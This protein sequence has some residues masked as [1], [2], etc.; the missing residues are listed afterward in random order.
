M[1]RPFPLLPE[2]LLLD[3]IVQGKSMASAVRVLDTLVR[4]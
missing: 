2:S 1:S 4:P 3:I